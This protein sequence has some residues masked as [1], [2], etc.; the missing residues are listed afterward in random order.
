M[1]P[2]PPPFCAKHLRT[3]GRLT[4]EE[5]EKQIARAEKE[6]AACQISL[7]DPQ[8]FRDHTTSRNVQADYDRLTAE[9]AEL[10]EEYFGR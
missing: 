7:A 3:Y 6:L 4:T 2:L 5:L 1:P 10:E 9:L 8:T